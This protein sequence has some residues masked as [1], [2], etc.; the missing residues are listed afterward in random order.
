MREIKRLMDVGIVG[1]ENGILGPEKKHRQIR[2]GR[3]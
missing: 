2:I 1:N 3:L